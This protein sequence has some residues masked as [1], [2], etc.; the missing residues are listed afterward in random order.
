[1]G[2]FNIIFP[3]R[4]VIE[5]FL[6]LLQKT[7]PTQ[8]VEKPPSMASPPKQS[9]PK[10]E[11]KII[12]NRKRSLPKELNNRLGQPAP[13]I[14]RQNDVPKPPG[15]SGDGIGSV[16]VPSIVSV[17][18]ISP[19]LPGMEVIPITHNEPP[20]P[21]VIPA[22][23]VSPPVQ[24]YFPVAIE[25]P[26]HPPDIPAPKEL[27]PPPSIISHPPMIPQPFEA[28]ELKP[29]LSPESTAEGQKIQ[30]YHDEPTNGSEGNIWYPVSRNHRL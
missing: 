22:P 4:L 23:M 20:P 19:Q 12:S 11:S 6:F 3:F 14:M 10:P 26:F 7:I 9:L 21:P 24:N 2:H 28:P 15:L 18:S 30:F 27:P 16:R 29:C 25:L 1:M 17:S 5:A 8:P 13:Q